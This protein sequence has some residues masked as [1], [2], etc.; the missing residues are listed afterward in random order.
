MPAVADCARFG[1]G[2]VS[3]VFVHV[4]E[5]GDPAAVAFAREPVRAVGRARIGGFGRSAGGGVSGI[6]AVHGFS[7]SNRSETSVHVAARIP[8]WV[9][10]P[11]KSVEYITLAG[12]RCVPLL[13]SIR[14]SSSY[15]APASGLFPHRRSRALLARPE[16][17][18]VGDAVM[19]TVRGSPTLQLNTG[20]SASNSSESTN[21]SSE[22]S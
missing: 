6:D 9:I 14:N 1:V 2:V 20:I 16:V 10:V 5:K 17:H 8:S 13:S 4:V 21:S 15:R 19:E 3:I 7:M 11:S 12:R 18:A 22:S